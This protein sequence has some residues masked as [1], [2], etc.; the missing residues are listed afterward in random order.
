M[1]PP[2]LTPRYRTDSEPVPAYSPEQFAELQASCE[3]Q[4]RSMWHED[5]VASG[6][7]KG[8]CVLGAGLAVWVRKPRARYARQAILV[9]HPG[10]S[11]CS[12]CRDRAQR[13]LESQGVQ[14]LHFEY[15][16]MD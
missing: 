8:T 1:K 12:W 6:G 2:R 5:M 9:S 15:G 13:W 10:Q 4:A 14:G 16:T 11:D 3:G 7:D